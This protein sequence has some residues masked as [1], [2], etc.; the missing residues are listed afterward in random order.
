ML[1]AWGVLLLALAAA[2]AAWQYAERQAEARRQTALEAAATDVRDRI[3]RRLTAYEQ[4]LHAGAAFFQSQEEVTRAEWRSFVESANVTRHFPGIQGLG[5]ARIVRPEEKA[6]H[7]AAV[8]REG[9]PEY[10]IRPEGARPFYAPIVFIEPFEGRNLRAFGYDMFSEPVR[11]AAMERARDCDAAALSGKVTLVQETAAEAQAGFLLYVPVY[12]PALKTKSLAECRARIAG[13]VYAPFRTRDFITPLLDAAENGLDVDIYDGTE[14]TPAALLF[15]RDG[16]LAQANTRPRAWLRQDKIEFAGHAWALVFS[17]PHGSSRQRDGGP[18][19][20]LAAGLVISLLLF[21]IAASLATTRNRARALAERL[22]RDLQRAYDEME[23]RV[24]ERSAELQTL[25]DASPMAIGHLI[26]RRFVKVNRAMERL[27]GYATAE[28]VGRDTRLLYFSDED[29]RAAGRLIVE[30]LAEHGQASFEAR[31]HHKDGHEIW[32]R[33]HARPLD[34]NDLA[35]GWAFLA[36]DITE[37]HRNAE[38]LRQSLATIEKQNVDLRELDRLKGEFLAAVTHELKTPLNAIIGFSELLVEGIPKPLEAE[39]KQFA[40]DILDAG[41]QLLGLVQELLTLTRA[42]AGQLPLAPGTVVVDSLLRD[43]ATVH[44]AAAQRKGIDLDTRFEPNL[45]H[46]RGD[47]Q[48]LRM[49]LGCLLSNALKFTPAGGRVTLAARQSAPAGAASAAIP[50]GFDVNVGAASAA[51]QNAAIAAEAA[52]TAPTEKWLELSVADTGAGI[53]PERLP[54][55][56]Q[57][58]RQSDGGLA[59]QSSGAGIG[60]VLARRL[61]ELHGGTISV[62]SEPGRGS[63]F[64]VRLPWRT[65][66]PEMLKA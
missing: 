23:G 36:E 52:P 39:Q 63:T 32:V 2:L 53:A 17:E 62:S 29:Y 48:K 22:N 31:V 8:R 64:T 46:F 19:M 16:Q 13:W 1:P 45:P 47:G 7:I 15:D 28:L 66:E 58:F 44:R 37:A 30:Q 50:A 65:P 60:L 9:F 59:R 40:V 34:P 51:I 57:P 4:M 12:R 5:Y 20:V 41:R 42:E 25:M 6:A 55:L 18:A 61:A 14:I 26:G 21:L 49:L 33:Y 24:A 10:A 27:S 43:A 35:K 56:F 54:D 11:R 3:L 38:A